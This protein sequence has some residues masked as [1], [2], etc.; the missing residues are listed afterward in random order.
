M[1][2]LL[3]LTYIRMPNRASYGYSRGGFMYGGEPSWGWKE[4]AAL[5]TAQEAREYVS[6]YDSLT[7]AVP[8][9]V[10][11]S[12]WSK[13]AEFISAIRFWKK[14]CPHCNSRRVFGYRHYGGFEGDELMGAGDECHRCGHRPWA[15][16]N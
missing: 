3:P 4:D 10:R 8:E 12:L 2:K 11:E 13:I 6:R 1:E 5:F 15:W 9:E 7:G 16:R 14:P